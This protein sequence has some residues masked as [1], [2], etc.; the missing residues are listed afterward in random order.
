MPGSIAAACGLAPGDVLR[1]INGEPVL[2]QV[3]Y[4]YLSYHA[5]VV[6]EVEGKSGIEEIE[7]EKDE[8]EPLGI[9]FESTLMSR[10]RRC[11]NKCVFCFVDQ[12]PEGLRESLYV[13]DDDWRLSLMM[14]NYITLTNLDAAEFDRIIARRASP[15]YLS[16]HATDPEVRKR[17][18]VNPTAVN[19]MDHLHRFADAGIRFHCQIV[20]CPGFNDGEVLDD[21]LRTLSS[22]HPAARTAAIVP[23][24]LTKFRQG[25]ADVRPFTRE[26]AQGIIRQA[27]GWQQKLLSAIGTRF[28]FPSDELYS[29]SGMDIPEDEAYEHY[30]QIENGVGLLRTFQNAFE[31]AYKHHDASETKPRR[32]LI[33]T[34]TSAAPFIK[35]LI[36][37]SP[38]PGVHATVLAV[39]NDFFGHTVTVSGLLTGQDILRAVK[40]A[41]ADEV[42]IPGNTLREE[43]DLFLD[44]MALETLQEATP[45][46]IHPVGAD[47]ADFFY[48]V[49][50]ELY[51]A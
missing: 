3:D 25:L 4:Q 10:P 46:P 16:I 14:G 33:A 48:A 5:T 11:R 50:G 22:L 41:D 47:G 35:K 30:P 18:M 12:M 20:L 27:H 42:L 24:G 1:K 26:E 21:T 6:L 32:V 2:D 36:A 34:G 17:M 45:L 29:M 39:Q 28:V 37:K 38:L 44:N 19:I 15:L 23:V 43:G 8:G 40:D 9:T 51:G 7:I 13:K 31:S 49:Q